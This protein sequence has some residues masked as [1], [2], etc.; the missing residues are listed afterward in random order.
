MHLILA[1]VTGK[2]RYN[3]QQYLQKQK[4]GTPRYE[5]R[6]SKR[7]AVCGKPARTV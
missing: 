3:Y 6:S 2:N 4:K 5:E 1:A 7:K